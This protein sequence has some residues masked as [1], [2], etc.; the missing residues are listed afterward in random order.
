[1]YIPPFLYN[2]SIDGNLG[3][4]L[5]LTIVN[6][7]AANISAPTLASSSLGLSAFFEEELLTLSGMDAWLQGN[8]LNKDLAAELME[9]GSGSAFQL[10]P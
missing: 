1:M 2:S 4:F 6:N 8:I 9:M 5:L 3:C 10:I 7:A